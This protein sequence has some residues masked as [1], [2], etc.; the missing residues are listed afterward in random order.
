LPKNQVFRKNTQQTTQLHKTGEF[1]KHYVTL[2]H[3][4]HF[5][6]ERQHLAPDREGGTLRSGDGLHLVNLVTVQATGNAH[7][8]TGNVPR[9]AMG[10]TPTGHAQAHAPGQLVNW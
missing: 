4:R 9:P 1:S 2:L 8:L 5:L 7:Q 3:E 10:T 6:S